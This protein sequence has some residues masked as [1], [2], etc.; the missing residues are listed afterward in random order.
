MTAATLTYSL[1]LTH[2]VA[3]SCHWYSGVVGW[4]HSC[5]SSYSMDCLLFTVCYYIRQGRVFLILFF[6]KFFWFTLSVSH[7]ALAIFTFKFSVSAVVSLPATF[8]VHT[9][10]FSFFFLWH[11]RLDPKYP[12]VRITAAERAMRMPSFL[13]S[14]FWIVFMAFTILSRL[15]FKTSLRN[16]SL[17]YW[18]V[19]L[20]G[21]KA[22]LL[23]DNAVSNSRS[24]SNQNAW[25]IH[26]Q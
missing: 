17:K 24:K 20:D 25:L 22:F 21:S 10:L 26:T 7:H 13:M 12:K 9:T 15:G 2:I 5:P 11:L 1:H 3:K 16:E 4:E 14:L 19:F 8:L 23:L 6:C 18:P